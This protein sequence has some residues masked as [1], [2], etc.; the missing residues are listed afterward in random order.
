MK[1]VI[2][3]LRRV[4]LE[5][6]GAG[7]SDGQLLAC[8]VEQRDET[9]ATA[10]VR[11]HGPMVWGVCRRI[12]RNE[13]D[14]EDA[15]QATFLVL[16]QRAAAITPREMVGN[17]LYGVAHKTALKAMAMRTKR[18]ARERQVMEMPEPKARQVNHG[19][20]LQELLDHELSR[21]PDKYR[22][23]IVLCDLGGMTRKEASQQLGVPEGTL[24]ARLV[25][26]RTML[27]KRLARHGLAVSVASLGAALSQRA[28]AACLPPQV[29]LST[30][31][32]ISAVMAGQAT[33]LVSAKVTALTGGVLKTMFLTNCKTM[34]ILLVAALGAGAAGLTYQAKVSERAD[35][36][37]AA[38]D[39]VAGQ[40]G[41]TEKSQPPVKPIN[42]PAPEN[43]QAVKETDKQVL[44]A[45]PPQELAMLPSLPKGAAEPVRLSHGLRLSI[46]GILPNPKPAD[47]A[48]AVGSLFAKATEESDLPVRV[49]V[50]V[51][52]GPP[53]LEESGV[54][55]F[56]KDGK[57]SVIVKV[58]ILQARKSAEKKRSGTPASR[59]FWTDATSGKQ[60]FVGTQYCVAAP[61]NSRNHNS[62]NEKGNVWTDPQ[63][64]SQYWVG[65]N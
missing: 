50:E 47:V 65:V 52:T 34:T 30:I 14:A 58:T 39:S 56:H 11:R 33:G 40:R 43:K 8:F 32:S 6:D 21:L 48:E 16:V 57:P 35:M 54:W 61:E 42:R 27:A 3:H 59:N 51:E 60:Y 31:K 17:W 15:F 62:R 45:L 24:A 4:V 1:E 18:R 28:A 2:Q 7:L 36:H 38:A 63:S 37:L 49:R 64:G 46:G 13:Q 53:L 12:L 20:E 55:R 25:R 26:A 44:S 9:A 41:P 10:L 22:V 23:A 29:M 5:Q 19:D